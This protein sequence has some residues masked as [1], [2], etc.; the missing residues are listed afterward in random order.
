MFEK[1]SLQSLKYEGKLMN[2]SKTRKTFYQKQ[3]HNINKYYYKL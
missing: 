2:V 3:N 1:R